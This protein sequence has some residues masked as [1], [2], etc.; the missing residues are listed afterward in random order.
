M[1]AVPVAMTIQIAAWRWLEQS[2]YWPG[3]DKKSWV[4]LSYAFGLLIIAQWLR[5]RDEV[6]ATTMRP[7]DGDTISDAIE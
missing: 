7:S 2:P 1:I 3:T 5:D 4:I 6:R